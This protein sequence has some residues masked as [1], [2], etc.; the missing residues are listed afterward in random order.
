MEKLIFIHIVNIYVKFYKV[1]I[2]KHVRYKGINKR[3][4]I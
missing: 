1:T 2:N 4:K 3:R